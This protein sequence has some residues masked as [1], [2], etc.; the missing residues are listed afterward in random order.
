MIR[1]FSSG[2]ADSLV[3]A[4]SRSRTASFTRAWSWK[5]SARMSASDSGVVT[6]GDSIS[7]QCIAAE[8]APRLRQT[9]SR[10]TASFGPE[11]FASQASRRP[12][13]KP[14]AP[15]PRASSS[16]RSPAL[17]CA[18]SE[19]H[20]R[21]ARSPAR[22]FSAIAHSRRTATDGSVASFSARPSTSSFVSRHIRRAMIRKRSSLSA[23]NRAIQASAWPGSMP[24]AQASRARSFGSVADSNALASAA[25]ASSGCFATCSSAIARVQR[26]GLA[27]AATEPATVPK[28]VVGTLHFESLGAIL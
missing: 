20:A 28:S 23:A 14:S 19:A 5:S 2:T 1:I 17:C 7:R 25:A 13:Q 22:P 16:Q 24:A 10:P 11:V 18:A 3:F 21:S 4:V 15:I 26:F 9:I 8:F 12:S 6:S 27:S